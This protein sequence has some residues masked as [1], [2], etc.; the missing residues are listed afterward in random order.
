[1]FATSSISIE[2]DIMF[3]SH[4]DN[5]FSCYVANMLTSDSTKML[6]SD[7]GNMFFSDLTN[8]VTSRSADKF[9]IDSSTI[10]S[11]QHV[12]Q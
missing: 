2:S 12:H 8:N 11:G 4:L 9:I 5:I 6:A 7:L 1:M 3:T 10:D